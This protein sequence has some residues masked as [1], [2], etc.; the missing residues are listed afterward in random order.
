M[1][2]ARLRPVHVSPA[3]LQV[4]A[5]PTPQQGAPT[6]PQA[7]HELVAPMKQANGA[8]HMLPAQQASPLAPHAVHVPGMPIPALR[9]VQMFV[10]LVQVPALPT[11]QHGPLR[12]PQ[13]P[14]EFAVAPTKQ[15]SG[16]VHMLPA[17]QASPLAPHTVHVPGV[18]MP[19][20]RPVQMFVALVQV[21]AL[22]VPQHG[23]LAAPQVPHELPVAFTRQPLPVP[24]Q[25]GWPPPAAGQQAWPLA[26]HG[27]QVPGMPMPALRP[28]QASVAPVQVPALPAPQQGPPC[29]PQVPQVLPAVATTQPP[30]MQAIAAAP[31]QHA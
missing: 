14:H 5:L 20:L 9:P 6:P 25:V 26:P 28:V 21:P 8:V 10:A 16:A 12:A 17:Q 27:S 7:P 24:V 2:L 18:P 19:A 23:P 3:P 13:A 11:P 22:P 29:A 15:P 4:P 1:L 30:V 31:G